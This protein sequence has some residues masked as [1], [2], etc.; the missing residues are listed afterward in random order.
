MRRIIHG[1]TGSIAAYKAEK[2]KFPENLADLSPGYM[3]EIPP[4]VFTG[5]P[6]KYSRT[7]AGY[8][9][10]SVG[11]NR[12]DDGGV[13]DLKARPQKDDIAIGIP[14]PQPPATSQPN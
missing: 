9:L 14:V 1:V 10:Y 11:P 4:D 12:I 13:E 3:K 6:L 8:L 5:Q 7:P 2:G